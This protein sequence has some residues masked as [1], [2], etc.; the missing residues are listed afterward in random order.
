MPERVTLSVRGD[1]ERTVEPDF[2]VVHCTIRVIADSKVAALDQL[3]TA[4][5]TLVH[6]LAELGGSP[7]TVQTRRAALTWSISSVGTGDEHDFDKAT[8][9]HGPTGRVV[10][11]AT[12]A[13]TSRELARLDG[14]GHALTSVENLHFEGI[15]WRV[16]ADNEN[17]RG[18][19]AD[20]IDAAIAKGRDY[21]AAL[22]GSVTHVEQI[23]DAGLL[24]GDP[25]DHVE[26]ARA[27]SGARSL[28]FSGGPDD[29]SAF[30]ALDP[31]PQ[32][33]RAVIEARLT[34][35]VEPLAVSDN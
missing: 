11:N 4:Q 3:A 5:E 13:I 28:G 35:E 18:V 22:R 1:A 24:T 6:G 2:V 15:A 14:L 10:A 8:G 30:A 21:A 20:A 31:V 16:D 29:R 17:W 26:Y 23:A 32:V 12:A 33:I 9:Q 7:L 19:R 25:G 27:A 34:A